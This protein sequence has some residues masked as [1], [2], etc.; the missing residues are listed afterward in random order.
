MKPLLVVKAGETFP[1]LIE[2]SGD[3]EDWIVKGL[4][5]P[6]SEIQV[7]DAVSGTEL[8]DP[9][10]IKGAVISG[11]H[12]NVTQNTDWSLRLEAWARN[13]IQHQVPLL[14]ICY[15]HQIIAKAM[16]GVVDF[17][18]VS[19]E[20]GTRDMELLDACDT[21][22]LFKGVPNRFK[23]HVFHS[24]SVIQLPS[25]AFVLARNDFE[26]HQAFRIGKNAWGVQ[27][28]P[29]AD[30]AVTRG[31]ILHLEADIK[32]SGQDPDL[33]VEQLE[34]TPYAAALLKRFG[35]L[36]CEV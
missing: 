10:Q 35:D 32:A 11:S 26:P 30:A 19:I 29:E 17:H 33:L 24:Q 16:G 20:I 12:D 27:F 8:P 34:E 21:D 36:V 15:G 4:G 6:D 14:G 2:K 1:E 13:L 22:P 25:D 31:Y 23:A 5:R 3:F 7:F 9:G 28:H 18:P